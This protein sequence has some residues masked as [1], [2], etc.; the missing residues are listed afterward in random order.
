MEQIF[1]HPNN[2][3]NLC[4]LINTELSNKNIILNK[5]IISNNV[6]KNINEIFSKFNTKKAVKDKYNVYLKQLNNK[7]IQKSLLMLNAM[8]NSLNQNQNQNQNI[9]KKKEEENDFFNTLSQIEDN[10]DDQFNLD[11]NLLNILENYEENEESNLS[12]ED[13]M[14]KMENERSNLLNSRIGRQ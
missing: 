12:F 11:N 9:Q 4:L 6:N 13:K 5:D 14:K 1:K 7:V 2:I 10:L 8:S 3:N